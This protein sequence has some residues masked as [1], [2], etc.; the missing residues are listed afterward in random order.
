MLF[1]F[2]LQFHDN[3]EHNIKKKIFTGIEI[4]PLIPSMILLY[5]K[6]VTLKNDASCEITNFQRDLKEHS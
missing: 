5:I 2:V 3:I 1:L 6:T 4:I